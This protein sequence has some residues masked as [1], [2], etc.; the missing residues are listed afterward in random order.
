MDEKW[1]KTQQKKVGITADEIAAI[2]GRDRSVVSRVYTGRQRMSLEL[3]RAFAEALQVPLATVLEKAGA[4][5]AP[6]AQQLAPG[7]GESDAAPWLDAPRPNDPNRAIATALGADRPGVDV[8]RVKG[9]AMALA[10]YLMGDFI[11][12]ETPAADR[13]RA[14]DVV[15]AQVYRATGRDMTARTIL[16]RLEPPVLVAASADPE[17]GRVHVVDGVNVLVRGKVIS[18]WRV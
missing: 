2:I 18:S 8:W 9:M 3:A 11:L 1:F 4:A 12:V 10:G 7:F 15:L 13:A 14:G 17:D 6:V 5:D 16:R